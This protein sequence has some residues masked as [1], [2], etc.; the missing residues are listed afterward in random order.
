M[1]DV[2]S[3]STDMIFLKEDIN[4][5][6]WRNAISIMT[7]QQHAAEASVQMQ[8]AMQ[9]Y[10]KCST[11]DANRRMEITKRIAQWHT[12]LA[13]HQTLE[14]RYKE[15]HKRLQHLTLTIEKCLKEKMPLRLKHECKQFCSRTRF[16]IL[17]VEYTL[18]KNCPHR[19]VSI[20]SALSRTLP[21]PASLICQ[22]GSRWWCRCE[23][24]LNI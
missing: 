17:F 13:K 14:Q 3:M 24:K 7:A 20:I 5:K 21:I 11:G 10:K 2:I 16:F 1:M 9:D 8:N 4:A 23:S 6:L 19:L 18:I 22:W 15:R 12:L